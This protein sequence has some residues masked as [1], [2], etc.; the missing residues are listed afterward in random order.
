MLH[1]VAHEFGDI[2]MSFLLES[3]DEVVQI[4]TASSARVKHVA[5]RF[6]ESIL[7][8]AILQ[9]KKEQKTLGTHDASVFGFARIGLPW[10]QRDPAANRVRAHLRTLTRIA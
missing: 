7:A 6:A 1:P 8:V 5:Q 10:H 4:E 3:G 9:R 2:L